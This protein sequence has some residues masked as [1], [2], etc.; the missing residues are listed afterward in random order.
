[1]TGGLGVRL[2]FCPVLT[3]GSAMGPL[4]TRAG[5]GAEANAEF[6]S[7]GIAVKKTK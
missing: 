1:M 5:A 3:Q 6:G 2:F 4:G 7:C